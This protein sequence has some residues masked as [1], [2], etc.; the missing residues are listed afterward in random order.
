MEDLE[1][2]KESPHTDFRD[3]FFPV[4]CVVIIKAV[5]VIAL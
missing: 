5:V 4:L 2:S 3:D 1:K